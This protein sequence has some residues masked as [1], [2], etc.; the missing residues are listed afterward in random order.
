MV[1]VHSLGL[2]FSRAYACIYKM[3]NRL[4]STQ[5]PWFAKPSVNEN[6]RIGCSQAWKVV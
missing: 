6:Q 1:F 2:A 3:N 5:K 4:G